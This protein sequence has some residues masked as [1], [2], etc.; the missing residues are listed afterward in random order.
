MSNPFWLLLGAIAGYVLMMW[1][2]PVRACFRDGF[3]VLGR[4][5]SMWV[6]PGLF[7]FG[8]ACFQLGLRYYYSQVLPAEERPEFRWVR[9]GWNAKA[10][11]FGAENALW[12][13]APGELFS[14]ARNALLPAIESAAGLF[15]VVV[16][17]F[18]LAA[19]A[20]FLFLINTGSHQT[21]LLRALRRRFG[22]WGWAAYAGILLC[23]IAALAKPFAYAGPRMLD[24]VIWFQWAQVLDWVAFLF[25]YLFGVFLQVYLILLAYCWVRGL[26]FTREH[27]VDFAIRR[28]SYVVKWA[29]VVMLLSTLF[30][31]LPLILKNF[32]YFE[33]WFP[34]DS[35]EIDEW[36]LRARSVIAVVLLLFAAVQI[37]L[38]FHS[39]SLR[40]A[41][42]DHFH[43]VLRHWWPLLWFILLSSVHFFLLHLLNRISVSGWGEGTALWLVWTLL[44]P[45]LAGAVSAWLLASWVSFYK[46]CDAGRL[47]AEN[48]IQF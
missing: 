40:K 37:T 15:N 28:F 48:W 11:L 2:S 23:A 33:T 19:V 30:I 16:A 38:T 10:G 36:I 20:A 42:V 32:S 3:R 12:Y 9:E 47:R 5:R 45:W 4:Y 29:A 7:G 17:T 6:L 25:E 24:P 34:K 1:T 8:Y 27:L 21:V 39:E 44:F 18:P 31:H 46:R 22:S 26:S 14:A 13:L 43:F 35:E 41:C